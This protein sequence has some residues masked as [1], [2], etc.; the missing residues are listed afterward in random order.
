MS[1]KFFKLKS[2][3][4]NQNNKGFTLIEL[5]VVVAIIGILSSVVLASL[6]SARAKARLAAGKQADSS[7]LHG[8]GDRLVA[9]WKFEDTSNL[10][11]DT[12]GNNKNLSIFGNP[13][14]TTGFNGRNA[15]YLS[16][17][18]YF[19]FTG[20]PLN[21][22]NGDKNT[23]SFWM[24]WEGT[25]QNMPFGFSTNYDLYF[26][27]GLFGFNTFVGDTYGLSSNGLSGR[28]VFITAVFENGDSKKSKLYIDGVDQN[29]SLVRG[30]STTPRTASGD[31]FI[32]AGPSSFTFT[33]KLDDVRIYSSALNSA[34]IQKLYASELSK[35]LVRE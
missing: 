23:V 9:E 4:R 35:F 26:A 24:Y 32:G 10:G 3:D 17:N 13:L 7:I 19:T 30:S 21:F 27:Y 14:S 12:S 28:W 8:I 5:L 2:K 33:G 1:D 16:A 11:L 25:D 15:V 18:N 6:N 22:G 31:G 29:I 20:L 34:Q